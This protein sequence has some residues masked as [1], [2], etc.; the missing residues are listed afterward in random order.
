MRLIVGV[1]GSTGA[2][3]AVRFLEALKRFP[4][5]ETH[6]IVS[7]WARRTLPLETGGS[8]DG[9]A[10]LV[11]QVHDCSDLASCLASGSFITEGMIVL[12]CSMKTLASIAVGYCD[13]LISRAADVCIKE[14][15]RLVLCPRET[16]LSAIHL[17]NMLKLARLGV[18]IV[19][20][21]P[22]YYSRPAT[23]EDFV[24][25]HVTRLL[26]QFALHDPEARRWNGPEGLT[27]PPRR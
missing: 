14:G 24:D 13:N 20:P 23:I 8:V 2:I 27:S 7:E 5:V 21:M 3:H 19:P 18:R 16:P 17:E 12:P 10:P 25:Q 6:L 22:A 15:R 4:E 26:D 9:L 11:A 1:T